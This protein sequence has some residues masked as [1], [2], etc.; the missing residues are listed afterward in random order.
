MINQ[1]TLLRLKNWFIEYVKTFKTGDFYY[2]QNISLKEEHT[3]RVCLEIVDV[4]KSLD[5]NQSNL[6]L[7]EVMALFHDVG[8]FEQYAKYRTFFDLV[9][10]DA[11]KNIELTR[12]TS[13]D[14]LLLRY[15]F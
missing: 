5:L 8:R 12:S 14:D 10:E 13:L 6:Y 2:L 3:A 1:Q 15:Q 7:A 11:G 4:G 9:S